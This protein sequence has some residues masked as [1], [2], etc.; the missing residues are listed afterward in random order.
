[1]IL[2]VFALPHQTLL[3]GLLAAM[4]RPFGPQLGTKIDPKSIPKRVRKG[5]SDRSASQTGSQTGPPSPTGLADS[6]KTLP[7]AT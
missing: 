5:L 4:L 2:K 1:M 6:P 3:D 7:D